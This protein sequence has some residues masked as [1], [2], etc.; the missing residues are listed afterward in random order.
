MSLVFRNALMPSEDQQAL[1]L[2]PNYLM[3]RFLLLALGMGLIVLKPVYSEP[4][5]LLFVDAHSQLPNSQLSDQIIDFLNKAGVK[6]VILTNRD[7]AKN[8]DILSLSDK[9]PNR[10][11]PIIKTKGK[12]WSDDN[13]KFTKSIEKKEKKRRYYGLGEALL[14]HAAKGKYGL[15]APEVNVS[16]SSDQFIYLLGKAR[17]RNWPLIIHIEFR[18]VNNYSNRMKE[19]ESILNNNKDI[20]FPLIHM[21]QL[22]ID[23][24]SQLIEKHKNVYFMLSR[25]N[26]IQGVNTNQPWT[27]LFSNKKIKDS[28][29]KL[30]IKYP[31]RFIFCIDAVWPSDWS[32]QYYV[33]RVNLWREALK[34]LPQSV[35]E[36]IAYK[37][38]ERLW[39]LTN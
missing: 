5:K 19:L 29:K 22:D 21:G 26:R 30:L 7:L 11:F 27:T 25:A 24:V 4:D 37:N 23:V 28:W 14:F 13:D 3:K 15:K 10:V 31:D 33:K 34:E 9:Y 17:E 2:R 38:A 35:V 8:N 12:P 18:S 39:D 32:D 16:S 36:Q 20:S 1:R 6:K